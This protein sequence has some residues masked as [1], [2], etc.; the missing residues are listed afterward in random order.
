MRYI[1][2]GTRNPDASLGSWLQQVLTEEVCEI[3]WQAGFYSLG[4]LGLFVP[5]LER[6]AAN[7]GLVRAVIGSNDAGSLRDDVR[8]LAEL[9][10]IPRK[11]AALA[12]VSY[13]GGFFHPKTYHIRRGD[14]SQAAYV[15]SA[16]LSTRAMN[17]VHIEAGVL[18]DT[19]EGEPP[20]LLRE[21]ADA[22]DSWFGT[23]RDGITEV[24]DL[25]DVDKLLE[26]G[27]LSLVAS[28]RPPASRSNSR[29][30][31][32][33]RK[34][35]LKPLLTLPSAAALAV[36]SDS[37]EPPDDYAEGGE[38]VNET[39]P[40]PGFPAY[41]LFDPSA[42][43]PT[44]GAEALSGSKLPGGAVGLVVR[45]NR[46]SARHFAGRTGTANQSVPVATLS[47]IRF[48]IYRGRYERPR[49]EFDLRI[50]YLGATA[51]IVVPDAETNI[52]A[53]GY[54]PN[55]SGHADIRLLMP[56]ALRTLGE[57]ITVAGASVPVEGDYALLEWPTVSDAAFR[58][59]FMDSQS[60]L[61]QTAARL[62]ETAEADNRLVGDGACWLPAGMVPP[63]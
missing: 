10:G 22:V 21:I 63:W 3:R 29:Q 60:D 24:G 30:G 1:D 48:G 26:N 50:R 4:G 56:A 54:D 8:R 49:A 7:D 20:S 28:P 11:N 19:R 47:T 51:S 38:T 40:K 23:S 31:A 27:I 45:L 14:G 43:S 37:T 9:I 41:L 44:S 15:G 12:V 53:Y 16:N 32:S 57:E 25:G 55:E 62:F 39:V 58:I 13:G 2:T 46:D 59:T 42:N 17:G 36:S 34:A 18:L 35:T 52:M 6:L 5:T 33:Y 61:Y